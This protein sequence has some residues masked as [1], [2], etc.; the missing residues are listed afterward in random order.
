MIHQSGELAAIERPC[1]AITN[2]LIAKSEEHLIN[3]GYEAEIAQAGLKINQ[4]EKKIMFVPSW[5]NLSAEAERTV[6]PDGDIESLFTAEEL[7]QNEQAIRMLKAEYNALH[8]LDKVDVFTSAAAGLLGAAVDILLV[9]I[10]KRS[11]DGLKA[12][13]LSNFIRKSFDERFPAGEMEKLANQ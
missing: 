3:L 13:P 4:T 7:K 6:S 12:G 5:E 9:G 11:P 1:T 2:D 8:K 10:P